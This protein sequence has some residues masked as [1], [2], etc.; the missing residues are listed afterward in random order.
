MDVA[1]TS[2]ATMKMINAFFISEIFKLS[3]SNTK[4]NFHSN[5]SI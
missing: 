2:A 1:I 3:N 4:L 5:F